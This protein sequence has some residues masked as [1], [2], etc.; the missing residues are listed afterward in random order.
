MG[1]TL[2][3]QLFDMHPQLHAHPYELHIGWPEAKWDWPPLDPADPPERWFE[4]LHERIGD[5]LFKRGYTKYARKGKAID[6]EELDVFPFL[7]PPAML[8]AVFVRLAH[9]DPPVTRRAI[10]DRY[11]TAYFNCWLDNQNLYGLDKRWV[12]GFAARMMMRESNVEAFFADYPDGRLISIIREPVSW[13]V[14]AV[15]HQPETYADPSAA[16][17]EWNASAEAMLRA[18]DRH[19]PERVRLMGFERLVEDTDTTMRSLADWLD[20][21]FTPE[22]L[23]PTFNGRP[24][25]ADSSFKVETHG[26]L[27]DTVDRS[28]HVDGDVSERVRATA[29]DTFERVLARVVP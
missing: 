8:R 19:G 29:G 22:L 4:L 26:I 20:I 24:I 12:T 23:V 27:R 9:Q 7:Q 16:T 18:L 11:W 25:K 3:S 5:R 2:L 17:E 28:N 6:G 14:S 10:F 1:G 21:A 13:Y 15:N